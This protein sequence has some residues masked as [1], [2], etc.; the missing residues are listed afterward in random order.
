MRVY[1]T[2][3]AGKALALIEWLRKAI[4]LMPQPVDDMPRND[5]LRNL[6]R[7]QS[8]K[9]GNQ[10]LNIAANLHRPSERNVYIVEVR[11]REYDNLDVIKTRGLAYVP[12]Y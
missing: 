10:V 9:F 3:A 12:A 5:L 4:E 6:E 8:I 11:N 2:V 1:D 7:V